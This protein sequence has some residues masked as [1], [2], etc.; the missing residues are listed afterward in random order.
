MAR[1][2]VVGLL[3]GCGRLGFDGGAVTGFDAADAQGLDAPCRAVGHDEDGDGIDDACDLCPQVPGTQQDADGD[4]VGDGCDP[5]AARHTRILFDPFTSLRPEWSFSAGAAI[6][7]DALRFASLGS[8]SG[9]TL[10]TTFGK[11]VY[12]LGGRVFDGGPIAQGRQVSMQLEAGATTFYCELHEDGGG[13]ALKYTVFDGTIYDNIAIE[14]LPGEMTS[15]TFVLRMIH[16]PPL[17]V[18]QGAWGG[19]PVTVQ[20]PPSGVPVKH[21]ISVFNIDVALDYYQHLSIE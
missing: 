10:A 3:A 5:G 4:G 11:D 13:F 7:G 15:G 19:T 1:F 16:E 12:E 20:G 9:G 17:V 2:L 21:Y 6:E 14:P 8:G 18:C